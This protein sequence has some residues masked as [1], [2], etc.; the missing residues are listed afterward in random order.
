MYFFVFSSPYLLI[1]FLISPCTCSSSLHHIFSSLFL[2]L[3]VLLRFLFT[4]SSHPFSCSSMHLSVIPSPYL[5]IYPHFNF[6][7]HPSSLLTLSSHPSPILPFYSP[8]LP[9][10]SLLIRPS[11][12]SSSRPTLPHSIHPSSFFLFSCITEPTALSSYGRNISMDCMQYNKLV[13][14]KPKQFQ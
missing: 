3:H 6:S 11:L 8:A 2:F 5:L 14:D 13:P 12:F 4:L 7:P 10:T 9:S 1:R